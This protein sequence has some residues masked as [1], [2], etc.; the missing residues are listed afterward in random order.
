MYQLIC[1]LIGDF[2]LII[3]FC[4]NT[5]NIMSNPTVIPFIDE[6]GH[7]RKMTLRIDIKVVVPL[8]E[9][10][11]AQIAVMIAVGYLLPRCRLPTVRELANYLQIA[12]GTIARSYTELERDG[13]I[14]GKGRKGTFVADEPPHSEPLEERRL[15]LS[16]A[17]NRFVYESRQLGISHEEA[18]KALEET[19]ESAE[20]ND[21]LVSN[22]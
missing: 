16:E 9:Q 11:R 13:L 10:I 2:L 4:T 1:L 19:F 3:V 14:R 15:R 6:K 7:D 5:I 21:L 8:F 12:P 17:V 20:K 22:E 18:R